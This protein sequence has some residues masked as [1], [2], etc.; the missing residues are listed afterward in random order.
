MRGLTPVRT[1]AL[2]WL[3]VGTDGK[4]DA[5]PDS[6][7]TGALWCPLRGGQTGKGREQNLI[8]V[9]TGALWWLLLGR[10]LVATRAGAG[11]QGGGDCAAPEG[12][13]WGLD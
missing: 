1:G 3:L 8:R 10:T 13:R 7:L 9:L 5:G 2:W 11:D 12:R 4:G 6:A